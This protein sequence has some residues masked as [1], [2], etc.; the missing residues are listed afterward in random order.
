MGKADCAEGAEDVGGDGDVHS[1]CGTPL[2]AIYFERFQG[3]TWEEDEV[4]RF[5]VEGAA[6][7][8]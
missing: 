6:S 1:C 2:G 7:D 8:D 4:I 5:I 3:K